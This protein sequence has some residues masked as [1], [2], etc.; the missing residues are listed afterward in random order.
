[1]FESL[2]QKIK[3]LEK[4]LNE[5]KSK[6]L[7]QNIIINIANQHIIQGNHINGGYLNANVSQHG[8]SL[9]STLINGEKSCEK[10]EEIA[11]L[12]RGKVLNVKVSSIF[13]YILYDLIIFDIL[14][15]N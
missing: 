13:C 2:E 11:A 14:E 8:N 15:S 6:P 4:D 3:E 1:M 9:N 12:F 7:T 10:D 5:V